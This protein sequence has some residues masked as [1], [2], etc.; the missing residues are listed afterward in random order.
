MKQTCFSY[1]WCRFKIKTSVYAWTCVEQ[2]RTCEEYLRTFKYIQ[3]NL[4][5]YYHTLILNYHHG[6]TKN[7]L[8]KDIIP[9]CNIH[10]VEEETLGRGPKG[11]R[12]EELREE[13]W[14]SLNTLSLRKTKIW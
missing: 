9:L 4:N 1:F 8:G 13:E 6:N 12:K 5:N 14:V 10:T 3:E 11:G 7:K 2:P